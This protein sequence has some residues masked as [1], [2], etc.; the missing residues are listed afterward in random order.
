MEKMISV[1]DDIPILENLC[2]L[3]YLMFLKF[4][5]CAYFYGGMHK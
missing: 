1:E 4:L 2:N 5:K 3:N